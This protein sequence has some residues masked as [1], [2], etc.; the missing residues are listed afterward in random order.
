MRKLQEEAILPTLHFTETSSGERES[1]RERERE[2]ECNE[3]LNM[4]Q[5][6]LYLSKHGRN[7][8]PSL[9]KSKAESKREHRQIDTSLVQLNKLLHLA[10]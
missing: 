4:C 10:A 2:R 9:F 8:H 3:A 7:V 6:R 1:E 5:C